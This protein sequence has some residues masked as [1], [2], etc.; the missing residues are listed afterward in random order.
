[1]GSPAK[2]LF[3]ACI[4]GRNA[5]SPTPSRGLALGAC[6]LS[7]RPKRGRF[8]FPE[9]F[10]GACCEADARLIVQ[11]SRLLGASAARA[12]ASLATAR[13]HAPHRNRLPP[14]S[15]HRRSPSKIRP[16]WHSRRPAGAHR[17]KGPRTDAVPACPLRRPAGRSRWR[18]GQRASDF[19]SLGAG[20]R[21][22][23]TARRFASS[24]LAGAVGDP[25]PAG[26][27]RETDVAIGP[28]GEKPL[29]GADSNVS[30]TCGA[31]LG[32]SCLPGQAAQLR[33]ITVII[34]NIQFGGF[35]RSPPNPCPC[36][37]FHQ[38]PSQLVYSELKKNPNTIFDFSQD[39][40]TGFF[41]TVKRSNFAQPP[42]VG[43][44][45]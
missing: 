7:R 16:C 11:R 13:T 45:F 34:R 32:R 25:P 30:D 2:P 18:F 19:N 42:R 27:D 22:F 40:N 12:A 31:I 33:F 5:R 35:G 15:V 3:V 20:L 28:L 29:S 1:M 44:R 14:R 23:A 41:C 8:C 24:G 21:D 26:A 39:R 4:T 17:P 37:E 10:L 36:D 6:M 38:R 43:F 9:R